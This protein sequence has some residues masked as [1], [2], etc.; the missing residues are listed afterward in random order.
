[1]E[2][3]GKSLGELTT[4]S[5][6]NLT[7][8]AAADL[9]HFRHFRHYR[10]FIRRGGFSPLCPFEPLP[11]P[12]TRPGNQQPRK[13][14]STNSYVRIYKLFMQNKPKVKYAKI[15]LNT[16]F[17]MRYEKLDI[18]LFRQTNPIQTQLKPIQTQFKANLSKGQN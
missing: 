2:R 16:Y 17:T 11:Q 8:S 7:L 14:I 13:R 18:W 10:H 3:N 15:N 6:E 12:A 4:M 9:A 5:I 1:L